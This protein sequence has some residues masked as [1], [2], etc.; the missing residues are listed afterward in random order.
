MSTTEPYGITPLAVEEALHDVR[1][2]ATIKTWLTLSRR[3][4]VQ[5][6][7]GYAPGLWCYPQKHLAEAAEQPLRTVKRSIAELDHRG[8]LHRERTRVYAEDGTPLQ[9]WAAIVIP[10]LW[11]PWAEKHAPRLASWG[12]GFAVLSTVRNL[13]AWSHVLCDAALAG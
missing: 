9:G 12:G 11:L 6:P 8:V 2:A 13:P 3:A 4:F 1:S 5:T 10:S 7:L